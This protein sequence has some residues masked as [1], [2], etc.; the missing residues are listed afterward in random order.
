M[1]KDLAI[2]D[3]TLAQFLVF[4]VLLHTPS[5]RHHGGGF[6]TLTEN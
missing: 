3:E 6:S 4:H 5:V 2:R 1:V